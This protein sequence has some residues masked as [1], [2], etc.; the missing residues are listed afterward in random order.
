ML[1]CFSRQALIYRWPL[2]IYLIAI[3]VQSCFPSPE[4]LQDVDLSDKLLHLGGYALLGALTVR[5]LK[6]ELAARPPWKIIVL[7]AAAGTIYGISDELHQALVPGR[8]ADVMDVVADFAGS[9]LGAIIFW[10]DLPMIDTPA[11]NNPHSIDV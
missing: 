10:W 1:N 7:A 4:V 2:V 3:F 11:A 6:R 5:M 8:S 9:T